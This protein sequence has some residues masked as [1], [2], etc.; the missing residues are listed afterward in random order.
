MSGYDSTRREGGV[1]RGALALPLGI[2]ALGATARAQSF[3]CSKASTPVETAICAS[4][5]LRAKDN[6]L[7]GAYSRAQFAMREDQPKL[8]ALRQA[9][10][11]WIAD[12]NRRCGAEPDRI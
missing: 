12:R 3:D 2:L 11:A 4:A 10:R 6:A 5:D 1:W 9:Q 7:A 8:D